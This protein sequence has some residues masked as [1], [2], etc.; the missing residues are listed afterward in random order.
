MRK[1]FKT[2]ALI[3]TT[4]AQAGR[5]EGQL[6]YIQSKHRTNAKGLA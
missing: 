2:I 6:Y 5:L 4:M 3:I 1:F